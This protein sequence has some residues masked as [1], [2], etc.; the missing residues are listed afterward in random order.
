M[1]QLFSRAIHVSSLVIGDR[2]WLW[3]SVGIAALG[4]VLVLLLN[5]RRLTSAPAGPVLRIVGWT[6]LALCLLN[7]LWSSSRPRS[8][9]NVIAVVADVSR[10]HL[11]AGDSEEVSRAQAFQESLKQG[12][13]KEP[14]GW[15]NRLS[16]DFEL[17]RYI[18][19]DRLQQVENLEP[20]EFNGTAS[21][22][23][24]ALRQ[25]KQRY[26][27]QPLAGVILLTDGNAT[28]SVEDLSDLS[29]MPPV[30]SVVPP[31]GLTLPD[32]ATGT[33]SVTQTAFDDA[34]VTIQV[35]PD[36]ANVK[37]GKIA[38]TLCDAT[39]LPL[40]TQ[41]RAIDDSSPLKFRH[42]PAEGGA[43]FYQIKTA[44]QDDGGKEL[45]AEATL[46]NNSQL[47]AVQRST[48]PR[49]IL[50]V[51]GR[52]N[53][54]F[55]FLRRAVETDP[56]LQIVALIRI[57]K[58][59]AKFDFRG[60]EGEQANSLFRGFDK[61]D[62]DTVEE[63]DEPVLI[64]LGTKDDQELR[65]GFPQAAEDLFQYDAIVIDDL[66][67]DFFL[68]DQMKLIYDFV[69]RRGGGLLMMA[70]QE[71]FRQGGFDRTPIGETLP[72]DVSRDMPFPK[73]GVRLSLTR[74][75]WLQPWVRLRS[76]EASEE[77]R[78]LSMPEF[79][80]V[81]PAGFIRPGAVVMAEVKDEEETQWPALVVQRFGKGRTAALCVGDL[82]R[83]R[84]SEGLRQL[85][86][87]PTGQSSMDPGERVPVNSVE[88]GLPTEDL[89]DHARACRQMIRWLVADVP[90]RLDVNVSDDPTLGSGAVK[91][92]AFVRG[93]DFEPRENADVKFQVTSP[94]GQQFEMTAEPSDSEQGVFEAAI[95]TTVAGA[96]KATASALVAEEATAD[97]AATSET[98][99]GSLG[100][101]YQPDQKEMRSVA[102]NR[103]L[104]DEVSRITKGKTL[105]LDEL[106][107]LVD[108]LPQSSAPL[109]EF[110]SWPIWNSWW[111]FAT[112]LACL[113]TDWTLRRRSGLP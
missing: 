62:P 98:L 108:S 77:E 90:K 65:N 8:Q 95:S 54:D 41:T 91:L 93:A 51:S 59:E 84:L 17:R 10:S 63:Y 72:I 81:N 89:S 107:S 35:Q 30:Y 87:L 16:Q 40:E 82:W 103:T 37:S 28:D 111:V 48:S 68:A 19:S 33:H 86:G 97:R 6:L 23:H 96:W 50:Y 83:W 14:V 76:D 25:I 46:V 43:V 106:E 21:D 42:R 11:V 71:S 75:G 4:V 34:P 105:E 102:V 113:V 31:N 85:Q 67:A 100:W 5:R 74:D 92:S 13:S 29:G 79:I 26:D 104:L 55:K 52:P 56:Q 22:L 101:A 73:A 78:I 53:W 45:P 9:A 88:G 64:R 58:K 36:I 2:Q 49:R 61:A 94:D 39:G 110:W 99:T 112:A 109:T 24:T 70:G 80:T 57:A 38:V 66:E 1:S 18:V 69:S 3:P 15:L 27:G 32:S 47:I 12:E 44:L 60:R 20:V 7:P